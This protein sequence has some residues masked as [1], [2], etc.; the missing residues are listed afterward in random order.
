MRENMI[1]NMDGK[2]HRRY[3]TLVQPSFVPKRA[4]WWIENWIESTVARA[5]RLVRGQRARRSQRR[6]SARPYPCSPS[7]G[8][9]ACRCPALDIRAAVTSD[10]TRPRQVHRD[11][12]AHH[13][14]ATAEPRDDLI[15][16]LVQAEVQD[17][18]GEVHVLSDDEVLGF[19]FLLLAAGSGTTWKQM[20]ITL[21]A[22]LDHPEWL[23]A[24]RR[25]PRGGAG[26]DR[27]VAAMDANR[28]DVRP[29]RHAGH[30]ARRLRSAC[31]FRRPHVLRRR[32][33]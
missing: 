32:Q 24:A 28:S 4:Q 9:S 14:G 20:G 1:L 25:G 21:L 5:H 23:A 16:V 29:L 10:G 11:R 3:R 8:A 2:R 18:D 17:E 15:S 19:A 6:S 30:G 33:P 27:G 31:R 26:V 13:R 22:L 7:P 12:A